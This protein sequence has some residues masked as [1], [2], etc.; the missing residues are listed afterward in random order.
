[1]INNIVFKIITPQADT[2]ENVISTS[3]GNPTQEKIQQIL[4]S[5]NSQ[6]NYLIGA[7]LEQKLVA[8]IGLRIE[9]EI[10]NIRHISV[11]TAYQ[12][13]NIGRKLIEYA[14]KYFKAVHLHAETDNEGLGFYK[15]LGF[16]C[17][18]FQGKYNTRY[19]C[20]RQS[21]CHNSSPASRAKFEF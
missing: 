15:R 14:A 4:A 6:D 1:M 8:V 2:L 17:Q 20:S 11:L 16:I 7:F 12:G 3:I 9:N 10:A 18:E 19:L 13:Q 5:Y 21:F